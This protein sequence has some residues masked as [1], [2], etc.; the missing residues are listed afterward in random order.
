MVYNWY[1]QP[2]LEGVEVAVGKTLTKHNL[3]S[4]LHTKY[5][6]TSGNFETPIKM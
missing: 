1:Q 3:Y 5:V 4:L 2:V 6:I